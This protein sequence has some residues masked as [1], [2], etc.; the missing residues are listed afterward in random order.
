MSERVPL[1]T[2]GVFVETRPLGA[3]RLAVHAE[4]RDVRHVALPGYLGVAYP[5]GVVHHMAL[6]LELD[7]ELTIQTVE[8]WMGTVPFEPSQKT[9]GEGCRN[10]IPNYQ[11]LLGARLDAAYAARVVETVGGRLGCFH[12]LSLAQCLPLAVREKNA[13]GF[14]DFRRQ[15]R[16]SAYVEESLRLGMT[17]TVTDEPCGEEPYGVEL[18]LR[19]EIPRFKILEASTALSGARFG[20]SGEAIASAR[21]LEGL[22]VTKGFTGAALE[23]IAGSAAATHLSALVIAI[24]P[25]I[26]QASGALAGY[27]KLSPDQK[28]RARAGTPQADSCHMW[29]TGGP[30]MSLA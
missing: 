12:V 20:D 3:D 15:I 30:L 11:R 23:R 2:R 6:D 25:V 10:A 22:T 28:L 17:G 8:T 5:V 9:W 29:R 13:G 26:P 21:G 7:H 14:T 18:A 1:H 27:L 4:L 16:V 24:T 19:L